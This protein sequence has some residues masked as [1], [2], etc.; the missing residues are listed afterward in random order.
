MEEVF[1][2]SPIKMTYDEVEIIFLKNNKNILETL[3][4][5]WMLDN[6]SVKNIGVDDSKWNNIRGICDSFDYEMQNKLK[7]HKK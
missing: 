2:Q 1:K 6:K 4:E 7:G 5:L 3:E